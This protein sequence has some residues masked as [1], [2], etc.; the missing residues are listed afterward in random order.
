M[1]VPTA[2]ILAS[3]AVVFC[4][5]HL[6]Y[7]AS[8]EPKGVHVTDLSL[9]VSAELPCTWPARFP[10]FQMQP[11]RRL[12]PLSAY[13]SEILLIDP[14]TGTQMDVPPHSIPRPDSGL[15]N[16][17]PTG[18][19]FPEQVP[20]WQFC[21]EACVIDCAE[22]RDA[23]RNG[24]SALVTKERVMSW[25][26]EHRPLSAGDVVLL[27]SGYSDT[28][29]RPLP[30]GRR[31]IADAAEGLAPAWPDPDVD[32]MEYL[33][34]RGVML[35]GTDSPSMGPLPAHLAE[36]THVAGLRHGMIFTEGLTALGPLPPTG[37]FYAMLAPK[38]VGT[39]GSEV[40]AMAVVGEPLAGEL[41]THARKHNVTDLSLALS[42]DLPLTWPGRGVG[43]HRQPFLK[44]M[45]DYNPNV[46]SPFQ[47]HMLDSHAG[48]HLVPPSYALPEPGQSAIQHAADVRGWLAEYERRF[49]PRGTSDVT[50]DQVPLSQTC[51]RARVMDVAQLTGTADSKNWPVSPQITV[52]MIQR[53]EAETGSLAADEIVLLRCG[54][55]DRYCK[56]GPAGAA[57]MVDPLNGRSEGWPAVSAETILY[58]AER[59]IA[60]V[61]TD[62]PSIGGVDPK[63]A[64]WT[65]WALGGRGMAAV[66]FLTGLGA[67]KDKTN[68]ADRAYF[69]F[70]PIKIQGC[71]GGHGR[72]L[73]LVDEG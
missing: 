72:A 25:E 47:I 28:Y 7:A 51:G 14:N 30:E 27:R 32:C 53:Y 73:A 42:P 38:H 15:P 12:G 2:K 45:F 48:T 57:C 44:V 20:P 31:F 41:I 64:L 29:Y 62:A 33:A 16:A 6:R 66:E 24:S 36:P 3:C 13:N 46:A 55:S 34:S 39:A 68:Q 4:T 18:L 40:R 8:A 37:A 71:H 43:H 26:R 19:L 22:L 65:Y 11:Y 70:A 35:V 9:L 21:G 23:A 1:Y 58:L 17:G 60:C 49:G 59:G 69:L 50:T 63:Q 54:W 5:V 61:G 67:L 56:A 52:E 10:W